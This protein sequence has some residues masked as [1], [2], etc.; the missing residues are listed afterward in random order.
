MGW[1]LANLFLLLCISII[2][3]PLVT[4]I[5]LLL[6]HV[7]DNGHNINLLLAGGIVSVLL[8]LGIV[9]IQQLLLRILG[10]H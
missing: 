4:F 6:V 3:I 5:I 1:T 10:G 2:M 9:F 7:K 8:G